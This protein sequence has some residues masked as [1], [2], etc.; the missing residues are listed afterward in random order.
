MRRGA[1]L[2]ARAAM[3]AAALALVGAAPAD[4]LEPFDARTPATLRAAHAG[5]P[6]V[7]VFWSAACAPCRED[8]PFWAGLHRR[9]P[10]IPIHLVSID[11]DGERAEVERLL[12]AVAGSGLRLAIASDEVPERVFHAVDPGWR[13]EVPAAWFFDAAH[14]PERRLGRVERSWA[15]SWMRARAREPG[16]PR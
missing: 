6:F 7:L 8:L 14:R 10:G 5:R 1:P 9:F 13:G 4:V 11:G 15:A 12:R 2:L 16:N 3:L